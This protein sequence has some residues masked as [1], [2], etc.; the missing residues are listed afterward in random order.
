MTNVTRL[1]AALI[2]VLLVG[3]MG[4]IGPKAVQACS[5]VAKLEISDSLNKADTVFAGKAL[6]VK[7]KGFSLLKQTDNPIEVTFEVKEV[8]KGHVTQQLTVYSAM[9]SVSC[10]Y[11]FEQGQDYLVFANA[12]DGKLKTGICSRTA[13]LAQASNDLMAL[14]GGSVPPPLQASAVKS[15]TSLLTYGIAGILFV[16]AGAVLLIR[17]RNRKRRH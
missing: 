12:N 4:L 14:G 2:L 10:G 17:I 3:V 8:W 9:S 11:T 13:T 5:C 15:N 7:E 16:I 6:S 1:A